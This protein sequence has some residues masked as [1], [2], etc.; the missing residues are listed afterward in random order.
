MLEAPGKKSL[1]A[2]RTAGTTQ[3]Q[4]EAA[5]RAIVQ[6][7]EYVYNELCKPDI[8]VNTIVNISAD[9]GWKVNDVTI[10][11]TGKDL[12][13]KLPT[14]SIFP[15]ASP[16][17]F[18]HVVVSLE[19][20][21]FLP[22]E[23]TS[24]YINCE[25]FV[26]MEVSRTNNKTDGRFTQEKLFLTLEEEGANVGNWCIRATI[27]PTKSAYKAQVVI[28]AL[29]WATNDF[30]RNLHGRVEATG[31]PN[32]HVKALEAPHNGR[33]EEQQGLPMFPLIVHTGRGRL[34]L[35]EERDWETASDN[36][37]EAVKSFWSA[38][39]QCIHVPV[40]RLFFINSGIN[41]TKLHI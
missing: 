16:G 33:N 17:S 40:G 6:D 38:A 26:K 3:S 34:D 19:S 4:I 12:K 10:K 41:C 24:G 15:E 29:P 30:A 18:F 5:W 21:Q 1:N 22:N 9:N 13:L 25:D 14:T 2:L 39:M 11:L 20:F 32:I 31:Y 23:L 37:V 36:I 27:C 7:T 28:S 8:G 35:S